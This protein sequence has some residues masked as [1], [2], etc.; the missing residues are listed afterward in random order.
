MV[1]TIEQ[2]NFKKFDLHWLPGAHAIWDLQCGTPLILRN[3]TFALYSQESDCFPVV[4]C[5]ELKNGY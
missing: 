5:F 1:P 3:Y 4:V 2:K